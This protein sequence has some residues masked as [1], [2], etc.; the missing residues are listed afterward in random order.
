MIENMYVSLHN[1]EANISTGQG[2]LNSGH[3]GTVC[4]HVCIKALD[5]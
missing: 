2:L 3:L 1:Q 4:V 5:A